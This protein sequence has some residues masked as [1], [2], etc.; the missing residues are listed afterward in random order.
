[1]LLQSL[2]CILISIFAGLFTNKL[3][4]INDLVKS[5]WYS[6]QCTTIGSWLYPFFGPS[7]VSLADNE[8]QCQSNKFDS[9]FSS[10]IEG[11][12][13]NVSSLTSMTNEINSTVNDIR[14]K[15]SSVE[16]SV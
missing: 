4:N 9:M 10:S 6:F 16:R 15:I 3:F 7:D 12:N 11:T 8:A 5:N 2:V 1:M 13:S 14:D